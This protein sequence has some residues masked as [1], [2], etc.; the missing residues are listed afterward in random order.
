MDMTASLAAKS[1]QLNAVDLPRPQTFTIESVTVGNPDQ[2]FN[3]HLLE[4]PGRPYRPSKGMRR[5]LVRGWGGDNIEKAYPGRRLTLWCNPEVKWAGAPVGG[6]Q[7]S[8]MSDLEGPFTMPL[9]LSQKQT[10]TYTVQPL[11]E[12]RPAPTSQPDPTPDEIAACTD[13]DVLK[14]WWYESTPA[15]R[16]Q[17]NARVA[18]LKASGS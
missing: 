11:V 8:A 13:L 12:Q 2:P 10:T 1:D 14:K 4:A 16:E 18:Q 6:I 9:R 5:V 3:F 17:I 15:T 7:I